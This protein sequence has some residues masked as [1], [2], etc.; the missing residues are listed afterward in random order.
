MRVS[1]AYN[2]V[3]VSPVTIE[4][5]IK[6]FYKRYS[7]D[8][9][10]GYITFEKRRKDWYVVYNTYYENELK[11][12]NKVL[13]YSAKT[14]GFQ[15]LDLNESKEKK[16]VKVKDYI[17]E[18]EIRDYNLQPFYGYRGWY[19]D[20]I[21]EYESKTKLFDDEL[22]AL[23]RA[24]S[25]YAG[26]LLG[27]LGGNS[28]KNEI[29]HISLN[30]NGLTPSR[31]D[32]FIK[33]DNKAILNFKKLADRNPD[34]KT[35]IGKIGLKYSNEIIFQYQTLLAYADNY[36]KDF[37][38]PPNL[39]SSHQLETQKKL[40]EACPQNAIFLS[41][42]DNDYYP[43]HYLQKVK[44]IRKDV[45]LVNYN[46]LG[47]DRYIFRATFPQ[48]DALPINL[49]LDTSFYTGSTNDL[50]LIKDS[51]FLLPM[52]E[53]MFYL[54]NGQQD[55]YGRIILAAD[56]IGFTVSRQ[57]KGNVETST[58]RSMSLKK[59]NYLLKN[60]WIILSIIENLNGRKLCFPS[61]LFD[62]LKILN[63]HLRQRGVLWIYDN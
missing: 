42:G 56:E 45:Y 8:H 47:I 37:K 33:I 27:D 58:K 38:F 17:Q 50:I 14:P 62:Q 35:I 39:Y 19:K 32:S 60:E 13:F 63:D 49:G 52:D 1:F 21:K 26:S 30:I 61:T 3:G 51:S 57:K 23:A 46:L 5:V 12:Q 53:F 29:W 18:Y 28:V 40:L 41:Y 11:P 20:V 44:G 25:T 2:Q 34:Y 24:Y 9:I 6:E 7:V 48:Y 10:D 36:A 22:Y 31:I 55:E 54:Q 16:E 15:K 59:I 4:T 43:I